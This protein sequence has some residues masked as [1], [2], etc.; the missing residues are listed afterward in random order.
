MKRLPW[1]AALAFALPL[2]VALPARAQKWPAKPV[3]LVVPYPPGGNVDGAARILA[4]GLQKQLGQP[5]I[6]ENK[7]GAGGMI[8]GEYAAKSAP[9]GYTFFVAANGPLLFSPLIFG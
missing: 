4:D 6:I 3:K 7:A 9:D 1:I 2:V 5:F 8:G